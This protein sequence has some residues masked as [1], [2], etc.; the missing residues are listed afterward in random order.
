[1]SIGILAGPFESRFQALTGPLL[2]PA[3]PYDSWYSVSYSPGS[4][5]AAHPH[6]PLRHTLLK[7]QGRIATPTRFCKCC[8]F[9]EVRYRM[10]VALQLQF[11]GVR[12]NGAWYISVDL[13]RYRVFS[14]GAC[15]P[16]SQVGPGSHSLLSLLH[17]A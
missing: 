2:V 10:D 13:V 3:A 17:A 6:P 9:W 11:M 7:I 4:G 12:I 14:L 15:V 5:S 8:E 16:C 1:M